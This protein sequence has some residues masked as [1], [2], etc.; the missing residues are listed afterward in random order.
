MKGEVKFLALCLLLSLVAGCG[1]APAATQP[2]AATEPPATEAPAAEPADLCAATHVGAPGHPAGRAGR[3][4]RQGAA[5]PAGHARWRQAVHALEPRHPGNDAGLEAR[6]VDAGGIGQRRAVARFVRADL[7]RE[8]VIFTK[9]TTES[10]N[11]LARLYPFRPNGLVLTT[12][13]EHHS[14]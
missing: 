10:I 4:L 6:A 5:H 1:S 7:G 2:P 14:N 11:K 3:Q 13:M 12:L 9:N 8:T